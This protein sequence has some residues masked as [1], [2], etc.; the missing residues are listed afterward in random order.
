M[1][2]ICIYLQTCL[3]RI[4]DCLFPKKNNELLAETKYSSDDIEFY[5][6]YK[7]NPQL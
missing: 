2:N 3:D 1:Y 5:M 7:N 4:F 6:I